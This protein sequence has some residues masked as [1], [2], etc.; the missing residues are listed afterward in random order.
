MHISQ[1]LNVFAMQLFYLNA[2]INPIL[3]NLRSKKYRAAAFALLVNRS[4][5]QPSRMSRTT[6]SYRETSINNT[7]IPTGI[8]GKKYPL[9]THQ[10]EDHHNVIHF[11]PSE[12]KGENGCSSEQLPSYYSL[13]FKAKEADNSEHHHFFH[14]K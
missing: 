13:V 12:N 14:L 8:S 5:K 2:C 11:P 1:Y 9:V 7:G 3:Y 4:G 10:Q 6:T